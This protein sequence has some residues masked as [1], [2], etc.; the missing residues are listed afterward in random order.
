MSIDQSVR[1][2]EYFWNGEIMKGDWNYQSKLCK[3][4]MMK[5]KMTNNREEDKEIE[6]GRK[7]REGIKKGGN[8]K[9]GEGE[10]GR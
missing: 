1:K 9:K 3:A 6:I 2:R 10:G 7:E 5:L 4:L 8:R